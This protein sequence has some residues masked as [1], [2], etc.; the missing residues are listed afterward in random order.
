MEK[1]FRQILALNLRVERIRRKL[2]Q[3]QLAEMADISTKHLT[4]IENGHVT[5]SSF[6]VYNLAKALNV[7]MDRLFRE[8]I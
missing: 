5:P 8:D 3:E 2:T 4:K 6:M 1:K 7:S